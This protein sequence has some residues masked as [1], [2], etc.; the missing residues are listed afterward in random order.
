MGKR[1]SRT[2]DK[3]RKRRDV[4]DQIKKMRIAAEDDTEMTI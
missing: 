4:N 2:Q 3:S 1:S